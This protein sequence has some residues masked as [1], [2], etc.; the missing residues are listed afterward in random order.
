MYHKL[1]SILQKSLPANWLQKNELWLRAVYAHYFVPKGACFC[2]VCNRSLKEFIPIE[3]GEL[4]CPACGSGKRHRRLFQLLKVKQKN[5]EGNI[6]DFSPN[7]GFG[8]YAQKQWGSQYLT[9]NFDRDDTTDF[10]FDITAIKAPDN[11]YNTIVCYHVLE[12]I[13]D[14][15]KAMSELYR[16]LKPGGQCFIQTPFKEGNIYEDDNIVCPEDRLKHFE[17]E[18]HVRIYSVNGLAE[19][20]NQIGFQIKTLHYKKEED[21]E[22]TERLGFK[23][24]EFII[25]AKKP[26][27]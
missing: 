11:Q 20:L 2:T 23:D 16:V 21:P 8:Y 6:L 24:E 1:K 9:T 3:K 5:N 25:L 13:P 26:A 12:H 27:T 17:Q 14:D 15:K 4:V 19:R 7:K 10:H 18:D 22:N